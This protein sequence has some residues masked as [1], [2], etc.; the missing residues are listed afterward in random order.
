M[1]TQCWR[2]NLFFSSVNLHSEFNRLLPKERMNDFLGKVSLLSVLTVISRF[3]GLARDILLF[4]AFGASLHGEA[5]ILAF[6]LPNLFRRMLGEGTLS[7][8]FIPI[9]SETLKL[10]TLKVAHSLLNKVL[11]RLV[12]FLLAMSLFVCLASFFYSETNSTDKWSQAA[13]LNTICFSY[14]AL[15]CCAA[16][17]TGALNSHG[18]FFAGGFSPIILNLSMIATLFYFGVWQNR[19]LEELAI[20]LSFSILIA[21]TLQF[22]LPAEE[23]RR[24]FQWKC[25]LDLK[26]SEELSRMNQI[27]W[28]GALGAAVI[29]VNILVSR[30]LAFSL[31][32]NGSLAYL[33]LSARLIELP[34]GVFAIS[35]STVMFPELSKAS[36][37]HNKT[38][39]SNY[40]YRGF[41]VTSAIILP[42]ALGLAILAGPILSV[43]FKW[44]LFGTEDV[45]IAS[46]ILSI[47]AAGLPFYAFSAF[48]VKAFHSKQNMTLPLQAA[49]ISMSANLIFSLILMKSFGTH[50]LAWANVIA[51]IG[52]FFYLF[53]KTEELKIG[54][55][56]KNKPLHLT[57][58]TVACLGMVLLLLG[59]EFLMSLENGKLYDFIRIL[60][61]IP[62]SV[63]CY[64]L[65]LYVTG[66]PEIKD[67]F[68]SRKKTLK[69]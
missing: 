37:S 1:M 23:L 14:V 58:I 25:R 41:R 20:F 11:S 49:I 8:A 13:K 42:A 46:E 54:K 29:Q 44:G 5:F 4:S 62:L 52:Q 69:D 63:I 6:T 56:V 59:M 51:A 2:R 45:K 21:G 19:S 57:S 36:S 17:V 67:F 26:G 30:F 48:L 50:G 31:D 32:E 47:S 33:F 7:S 28:I 3:L 38:L 53:L 35:I 66:F 64:F 61:Y 34:L 40:L 60:I 55:I 22:I 10:K 65:L 68:N 24:K 27:F 15:I 12:L 16:I 18:R 39:F 43:L 9:Y